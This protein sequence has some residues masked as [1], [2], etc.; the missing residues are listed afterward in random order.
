MK[1]SHF[2]LLPLCAVVA[3]AGCGPTNRAPVRR[4]AVPSRVARV[5]TPP[6]R[7][8]PPISTRRAEVRELPPTMNRPSGIITSQTEVSLDPFILYSKSS[9][10]TI[11]G[12]IN[13]LARVPLAGDRT[14]LFVRIDAGGDFPYI[15]LGPEQW[16]F[17]NSIDPK[18]TNNILAVGSRSGRVIL[19]RKI[20]LGGYEYDLRTV[21]GSPYWD[22][23]I[24]LTAGA[25]P[26]QR[27]TKR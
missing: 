19:A 2:L 27:T 10:V 23:P 7:E 26:G 15:Y 25:E 3:L 6:L 14:G 24:T 8:A 21:N 22:E 12:P 18:M 20:I 1:R 13:G 16:L 17:A 4:V 11:H 9:E 5:S